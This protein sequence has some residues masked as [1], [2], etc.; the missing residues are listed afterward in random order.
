MIRCIFISLFVNKNNN[1]RKEKKMMEKDDIVLAKVAKSSKQKP[2]F[3][4]YNVITRWLI[5]LIVYLWTEKTLR[6]CDYSEAFPI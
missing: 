2:F 5:L 1:K 3:C 6:I 4:I